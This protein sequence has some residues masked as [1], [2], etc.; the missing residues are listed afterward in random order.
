MTDVPGSPTVQPGTSGLTVLHD[1]SKS[2]YPHHAQ[3]APCDVLGRLV[4]A[5]PSGSG[6][7]DLTPPHRPPIFFS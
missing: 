1:L 5:G 4:G 3:L 7:M 2:A 6:Q